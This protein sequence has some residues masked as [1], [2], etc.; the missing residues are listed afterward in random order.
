MI[1][2]KIPFI[3]KI[4]LIIKHDYLS[5][6]TKKSLHA[7]L[8]SKKIRCLQIGAGE[9]ELKEWFNTDFLPRKN[10]AFLDVTKKFKIPA[11]SF[12]YVFSEHHIEHIHYKEANF[13]LQELYHILKKGGV[14]RI[15]TPDLSK[16]LKTYFSTDNQKD[17]YVEDIMNNWIKKGF[18]NAKNFVPNNGLENITFFINDIFYNY[19]HKFIYDEITLI[20]L[21]KATGFRKAYACKPSISVHE[22]L[23][24]IESH[25]GI[26][27]PYTLVIE[28]VK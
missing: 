25:I 26:T 27:M 9:N 15:C 21:L 19:E 2:K 4:C 1:L 28:A 12:D 20:D 18:H 23:N 11:E 13:M 14:L 10:I 6:L 5:F 7:Y 3:Y 17:W 8:K 22:P 16:Y 24:G